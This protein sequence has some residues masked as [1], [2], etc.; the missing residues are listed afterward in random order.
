MQTKSSELAL[1]AE[2][3][4]A[5]AAPVRIETEQWDA[6]G[7]RL[8][9][10]E[11]LVDSIPQARWCWWAGRVRAHARA[12]RVNSILQFSDSHAF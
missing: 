2:A 5:P 8:T 11:G 4:A 9:R 12:F 7:K 1:A 10:L 3:P 6:L